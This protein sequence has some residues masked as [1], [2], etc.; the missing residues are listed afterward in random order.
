VHSFNR[1]C[2]VA[3]MYPTILYHELCN[4]CSAV[5]EMNDRLATTDMVR[6]FGKGA[7]AV[8]LTGDLGPHLT[9]CGL[10][11]GLPPYQVAS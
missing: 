5:A 2:Q 3:P 1:I 7:G 6:K 8:P 9:Q 10:G 4:K 11:Q